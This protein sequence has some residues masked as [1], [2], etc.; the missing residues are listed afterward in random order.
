MTDYSQYRAPFITERRAKELLDAGKCPICE[1]KL[2]S[3][4]HT[5]CPYI[6]KQK[7]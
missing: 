5:D 2:T 7:L 4:Y 1:I 3:T 6:H